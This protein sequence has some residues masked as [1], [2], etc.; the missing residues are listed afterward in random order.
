MSE[1]TTQAG[2]VHAEWCG[3]CKDLM[4]KWREFEGESVKGGSYNGIQVQAFE[5]K[6]DAGS[7]SKAGIE[8][9]SF[10]K[11]WSKTE[12]GVVKYHDDVGR[13]KDGIKNWLDS[14]SGGSGEEKTEEKKEG[15]MGLFGGGKRKSSRKTRKSSRKTMRGGNCTTKGYDPSN[16][17]FPKDAGG[18]AQLIS[19]LTGSNCKIIDEKA[20]KFLKQDD[21]KYL[22]DLHA[23]MK[24]K[25]EKIW[26]YEEIKKE[27][28]DKGERGVMISTIE[29]QCDGT[30]GYG[31]ARRFNRE[32]YWKDA[33]MTTY[34]RVMK[35]LLENQT[36]FM[37]R[38]KGNFEDVSNKIDEYMKNFP[39][40]TAGDNYY[41][42]ISADDW[43]EFKKKQEGEQEGGKR[44]S[45]RKLRRSR[46]KSRR[47]T[48]KSRRKLRRSR[49]KSRRSRSL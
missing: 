41:T 39:T 16:S 36:G 40:F 27:K 30:T 29:Q 32:E 11:F 42:A 49:R 26:N 20:L 12:G 31:C 1:K 37:G 17:S 25:F 44:K 22:K 45:R 19:M 9:N 33:V 38:D 35:K 18:A 43:E 3:H 14:L 8:V 2:V 46:R 24:P 5:E 34:Y 6:Q 15:F 23:E 4:P 48:R 10:P 13:T 21:S 47:K 7:I 28:E